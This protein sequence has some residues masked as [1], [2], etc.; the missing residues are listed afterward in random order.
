MA[1]GAP[2]RTRTCDPQLRRPLLCPAELGAHFEVVAGRYA[3]LVGAEGF[4]PSTSCP[5]SRC[6]TRLRHTPQNRSR[7]DT[8]RL[9]ANQFHETRLPCEQLEA[10]RGSGTLGPTSRCDDEMHVIDQ[11]L[12]LSSRASAGLLGS[13]SGARI[14][15]PFGQF[16]CIDWPVQS[17]ARLADAGSPPS[18]RQLSNRSTHR[19]GIARRP[20]TAPRR[21]PQMAALVSESPPRDGVDHALLEIRGVQQ[22]CRRRTRAPRVWR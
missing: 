15:Q 5:Q 17:R 20:C 4:E 6:A 10:P 18:G 9:R 2:G 7:N 8:H 19:P 16:K 3:T 21:A 12:V 13:V 22:S 1:L 14:D 11:S